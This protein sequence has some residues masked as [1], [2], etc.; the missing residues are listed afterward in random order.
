[1]GGWAGTGAAATAE[2]GGGGGRWCWVGG[3]AGAYCIGAVACG[4]PVDG[5][6]LQLA[7]AA[8]FAA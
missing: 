1:M 7:A 2:Y 6:T 4:N 5:F 8:A 3:A